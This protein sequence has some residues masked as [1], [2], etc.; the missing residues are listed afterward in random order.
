MRVKFCRLCGSADI[1]AV[2]NVP[3]VSPDDQPITQ[4]YHCQR[5]W[6][7]FEVTLHPATGIT[8]ERREGEPSS[9]T[10]PDDLTDPPQQRDQG[11]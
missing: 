1:Q 6:R 2:G 4:L 5:C 10:L 3:P 7:T 11:D 8:T 9:I